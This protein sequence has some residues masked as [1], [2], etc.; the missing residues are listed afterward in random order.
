MGFLDSLF[1]ALSALRMNLMRSVLT[2]LGII[3]GVAAVIIMVSVGAGAQARMDSVIQSLGSNL[4]VIVPGT[5]VSQGANLGTGTVPTLTENDAQALQEEIESI[6]IAGPVVK[7]RVHV[8]SGNANWGTNAYGLTPEG[9]EAREWKIA[10]GRS[11]TEEDVST[12]GKVAL[13]G[14]TVVEQI[15]PG[16]SPVGMEIRVRKVPFLVVGTLA[17][18]GQ[19]PV[20][21]DQDDAVFVPI[22]TARK[23][24]LG[25]SQL[26]GKV[27][28]VIVVK[29]HDWA[30]GP[31]T[32][33]HVRTLLR[34]RHRL[35]PN[36]ADDF[37]IRNLAEFL[38][39][40]AKSQR[41][42][43]LLLAIVASV[44]LIVGGIGIM[45]IMLVSVTERTREIGLRMAVGAESRDILLQFLIESIALSALGGVIGIILGMGG[46]MAL[47][48]LDKWPMVT[49]PES[50]FLAFG[51]AAAVGI[52]FGFYPAR[53]ASRLNPI[54]ALRYE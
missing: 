35:Q 38:D 33:R 30:S 49:K 16:Q 26:G 3:I 43:S 25:G 17:A 32:V 5:G 8:V 50:A 4:L 41:T 53:K 18:K 14:S 52:F 28:S 42:M 37:D 34:Q 2:T 27:V 29:M 13:L 31:E 9:L 1:T 47:A 22:T 20:G 24:L 48:S 21:T 11:L 36:E 54:E 19:T 46:S 44:S 12:S 10:E 23:R 40:R 45:N 51:F 39:A 6:R 15:C 7:G